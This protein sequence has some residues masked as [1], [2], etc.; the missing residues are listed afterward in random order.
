MEAGKGTESGDERDGAR[1]ALLG[2]AF[3]LIDLSSPV[4]EKAPEPDRPRIRRVGHRRGGDLL[5]L[6]F[7][8]MQSQGRWQTLKNVIGWLFG[9]RRISGR[10]FP[11]GLGL[12]LEEVKSDLHAG[13]HLDAP[14]HFGPTSEGCPAKTI[15]EVP[16]EWC[17]GEGL[18]LDLRG[19][20]A[21]EEITAEHLQ[22]ALAA[23]DGEIGPGNIVLLMTGA[24]RYWGKK[25]YLWKYPGMG[26]E[27]TLWLLEQ[28]VRVIGI[29]AFGFDRPWR[30]MGRDYLARREA[31]FLWPAHMVG[32]EK[33][34]CHIEKMANLHLIPR[35]KGFMVACFPID[36]ESCGAGWVRPVAIV[37]EDG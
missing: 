7:A 25:E 9:M 6:G 19:L 24:D 30:A 14:W 29:D 36:V 32:R 16:L 10:D 5:G 15:G 28:G 1:A 22:E 12:A 11:E 21:G 23:F 8:L 3:R 37:P 34:Y 17:F 27:G 18:V 2:G 26:R 31:R 20:Q 33:E 35:P 4:T 13:S